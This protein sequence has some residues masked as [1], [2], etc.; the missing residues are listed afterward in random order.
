M[1]SLYTSLA[2]SS[3]TPNLGGPHGGGSHG[4]GTR[5]FHRSLTPPTG[6]GNS[7]STTPQS[8]T[9]QDDDGYPPPD[10]GLPAWMFLFGC[11]WIECFV[12]GKSTPSLPRSFAG[13]Q[14]SEEWNN[15]ETKT[16]GADERTMGAAL[17]FSYGVFQ[18]YYAGLEVFRGQGGIAA[19][20]TSTLV[21]LLLLPLPFPLFLLPSP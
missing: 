7:K 8:S 2:S 16:Y 9:D 15:G 1:G 13:T 10:H 14:K 20:G 17:P 21:S 11:F 12:W 18:S 3:S 6:P 4:D 19:V 5:A